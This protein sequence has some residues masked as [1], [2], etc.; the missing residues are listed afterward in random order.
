[1]I[2]STRQGRI[3]TG[4][5]VP[6]EREARMIASVHI[7]DMG[8]PVG[9]RRQ[10]EAPPAGS[11]AGLRSAS[12]AIAA[13]LS[14]KLLGPVQFG[15]A[16]LIAFWDD[17]AAVDRFV[18][19]HPLAERF[20]SGWNV[21]LAPLRAFGTWPGLPADI[22]AERHVDHEGPVAVLT[23]GRPRTSELVRFLR[24]SVKAAAS[25][26]ASPG[27]MWGTAL[28][29]PPSFVATCSLWQS[30]LAAATFAYGHRDPGHPTR[31]RPTE[32]KPF[33]HESAFVR[34]HPYELQGSLGGKNP[35]A[36]GLIPVT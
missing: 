15:R 27:M 7:A 31:S 6:D 13:P 16:A 34:F 17:D 18:S 33:H 11:I 19:G 8:A 30:S 35:L 28:A 20:A 9:T 2:R 36:A 3:N 10:P 14:D 5:A 29:R 32:A 4:C 22:T 21:R 12:V 25:A 26:L 1:M 23:L 24:T